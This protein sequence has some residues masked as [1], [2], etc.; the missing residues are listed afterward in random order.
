[1]TR[2]SVCMATYNG[3]PYLRDQ[4]DSILSQLSP[5]DEL[6]V[7]DDHSTDDTR[8]I[9]ESYKDRRIKLFTNPGSR[10]HVQNFA[11]A[12][13]QATGEFIALADQDDIWVENRLDK[14]LALLRRM[15]PHSLVIGDVTEFDSHGIRAMQSPLGPTPSGRLI[16]I[17]RI[18]VGRLRYFGS[19]FLFRRDLIR[20]ILPIPANIEAHDVWISMVACLRGS[21]MHLE[22]PVLMRRIHGDN[23]T[24]QSRRSLAKVAISRWN[25]VA[26]LLQANAR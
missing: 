8:A 12:M 14:M 6:I 20:Y 21:V 5:E 23:L 22:E 24:P 26:A 16:G 1:M 13:K 10:G 2:V 11:H 25:Y 7:S 15:P 3:S 4:L 19:A 17:V 9:V 18:F